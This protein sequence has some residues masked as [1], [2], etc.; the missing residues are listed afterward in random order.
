MHEM[1][2]FLRTDQTVTAAWLAAQSCPGPEADPE[3]AQTRDWLSS[4]H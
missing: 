3:T 1:R 4:R 2:A